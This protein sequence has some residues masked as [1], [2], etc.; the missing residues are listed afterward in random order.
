[1]YGMVRKKNGNTVGEGQTGWYNERGS[2]TS[3]KCEVQEWF[4]SD[5]I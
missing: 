3:V 2:K 4:R 1:M 5:N